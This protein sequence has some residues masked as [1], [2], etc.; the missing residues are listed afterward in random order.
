MIQMKQKM[1]LLF[2]CLAVRTNTV[3]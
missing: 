3:L 1:T 2:C